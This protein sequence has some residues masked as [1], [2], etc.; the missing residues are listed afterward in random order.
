MERKV[1][2]ITK[3]F[4][5]VERNLVSRTGKEVSIKKQRFVYVERKLVSRTKGLFMWKGR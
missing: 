4:V 1:V 3:R 2:S 5:Y